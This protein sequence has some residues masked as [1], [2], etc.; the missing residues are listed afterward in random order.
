VLRSHVA[1]QKG[2]TNPQTHTLL[3]KITYDH[4]GRALS[5]AKSL[6]NA[7]LKTVSQNTYNELGQLMQKAFG[8]NIE[9]QT[10]TYNMRGWLLG[11]NSSYVG[12][13][14]SMANYF[15]ETLAYDYGFTHSQL[16]GNIAGV[17]WKAGGDGVARAYGYSYDSANRLAQ[18]NFTQ[19]NAGASS[20]TNDL[21]DYTVGGL[22][23]DAGGNILSVMQKGLANGKP[24]TVDSLSYQYFANS[25]QLQKV[26]DGSSVMS[27]LGDFKDS[28]NAGDDY[29]Y[30]VN[31]NTTRDY[32]R[33]MVT[34]AGGNGAVYNFL[35]KPDSIVLNGKAGIHYT[36][37]AGGV[38]LAK[39]MNDYTSGHLVLK[40][41]QYIGGFVYLNDTLQ[42][43]LHE[44][45]QIRNARKVN[46][47]TGAAYYAYEYDYFI[48]DH[49]GNVR[50]VLTEG[51]DTATYAA[52]MES[53]DSAVVAATFSNVYSPAYTVTAKPSGFDTDTSNHNVTMLNPVTGPSVGPSIVLKVMRGDQVQLSTYSFYNTP[54]QSPQS[55]INLLGSILG[56]LGNGVISS[57]G[58]L[59]VGDLTG[60]SSALSPNVTQFLNTGRSYDAG[61]PKAYLN[62]ILFDDQFNYVAGNSGVA[63]VIAG[64]SKQVL[65]APTQSISKNG[66][67][68]VYVSN[69]SQQNVYFDNLTVKQMTGPLQQEQ[70][71]YPFGLPMAGISDKALL[72]SNTPYK[73]NSG[74]ELEE[75]YG[76]LYYNTLFRKYDP[77]IGRFN[78]IDAMG[79]STA[80]HS[81]YHFAGN[82]PVLGTDPT[83]LL[84]DYHRLFGG[85]GGPHLMEGGSSYMDNTFNDLDSY[86]SELAKVAA[87]YNSDQYNYGYG[88]DGGSGYGAPY[89]ANYS[90]FWNAVN[91]KVQSALAGNDEVSGHIDM[92]A[93]GNGSPM[94][95]DYNYTDPNSGEPVVGVSLFNFIGDKYLIYD[96]MEDG[97]FL[98]GANFVHGVDIS[99]YNYSR[100]NWIQLVSTNPKSEVNGRILKNPFVDGFDDKGV[101]DNYP[102]YNSFTDPFMQGGT[103]IFQDQPGTPAKNFLFSAQATLIG[104]NNN[105]ITAITTL[106]WGYRVTNGITST[107]P[108]GI[109][110][111]PSAAMKNLITGMNAISAYNS[112]SY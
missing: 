86:N 80:G 6:D 63:Q 34:G 107:L 55:G 65:A 15:G 53:K 96:R 83:G 90:S 99:K 21:V 78:G 48:K 38:Q 25:N 59:A 19:Q 7:G 92:S 13:S 41:W 26:S 110:S 3:T 50:T 64:S 106:F 2:G 4:A 70:S 67:L 20:W 10:Y 91:T 42:F 39:Q 97:V 68:Y 105:Q 36:Y 12:T 1:H 47:S 69:E 82:N 30:D 43:V 61:R 95:L 74:T 37:D 8:S 9:T 104:I 33:H 54:V 109:S 71:Y 94:R 46:S 14:G 112:Y 49:Q 40:T 75:D 24:A 52:T 79:E 16:N 66:Y 84:M 100:Y 27:L 22:S 5:V 17:V 81:P 45:G 108:L 98:Y 73:A 32:N 18:A 60:V 58:H 31:G 57:S 103:A 101:Y 87:W 85:D 51:S 11:I 111:T 56:V 62:W 44:E 29:T 35:N 89:R 102:L 23:Y 76:L 72:K 88:D 77:Q 28:T 93:Y